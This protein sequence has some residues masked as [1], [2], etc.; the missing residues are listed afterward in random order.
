[1]NEIVVVV[2]LTP[3]PGQR[4][5]LL[6][7]CRKYWPGIQE[8]PGCELLALHEGPDTFVVI[9]RWESRPLWDQHLATAENKALNAALS[10]LLAE[11]AQVWPVVAL[12]L[13]HASKSKL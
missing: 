7:I 9:E 12:P 8:E 6:E 2:T 5:Q 10:P 1:M 4:V 11:P 3:I 13:G